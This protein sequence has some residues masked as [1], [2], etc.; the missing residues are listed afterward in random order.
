ME[1]SNAEKRVTSSLNSD[2]SHFRKS[3]LDGGT[4]EEEMLKI[5]WN[6]EQKTYIYNMSWKSAN[7]SLCSCIPLDHSDNACHSCLEPIKF[8]ANT[9]TFVK[10]TKQKLLFTMTN[11]NKDINL[12]VRWIAPMPDNFRDIPDLITVNFMYST[13]TELYFS[14]NHSYYES[15][16]F[17]GFRIKCTLVKTPAA[18]SSVETEISFIFNA[19]K[20][21]KINDLLPSSIYS[22]QVKMLSD[23]VLTHWHRLGLVKT[24]STL[25]LK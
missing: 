8:D 19:T 21:Y 18:N 17:Y 15:V 10:K 22:V 9:T 2:G 4:S 25:S 7:T 3:T 23:N 1:D 5:E 16:L 12:T 24:K 11:L 14:S 20:Q 6:Y 13:T